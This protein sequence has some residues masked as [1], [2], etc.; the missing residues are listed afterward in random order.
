MRFT[1]RGPKIEGCGTRRSGP[2]VRLRYLESLVHADALRDDLLTA[3]WPIDFDP[4]DFFRIAQAKI[5]WENALRQ[6]SG[7]A[8][9]VLR[10]GI[11]AR[12][13]SYRGAEAVTI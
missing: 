12:I 5:K 2:L 3:G 13:N 7:F 1:C 11:S 9:V 6:V 10:I 8:V 4:I